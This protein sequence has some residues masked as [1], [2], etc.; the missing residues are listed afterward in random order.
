M[1]TQESKRKVKTQRVELLFFEKY[2]PFLK[3]CF[4]QSI[5]PVEI[6]DRILLLTLCAV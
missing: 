5:I 6:Q 2:L 4:R 1:Q 3:A